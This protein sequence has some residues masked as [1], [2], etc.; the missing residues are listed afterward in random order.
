M[1]EGLRGDGDGFLL[2]LFLTGSDARM[3]GISMMV[4]VH[5][6]AA[7]RAAWA[8]NRLQYLRNPST[9]DPSYM[10]LRISDVL[11]FFLGS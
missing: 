8:E 10:S 7:H 6:W 4:V 9:C 1:E 5:R 11:L 3:H 2:C